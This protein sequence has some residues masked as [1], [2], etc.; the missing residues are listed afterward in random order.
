MHWEQRNP[1]LDLFDIKKYM[2]IEVLSGATSDLWAMA[3][4]SP[5]A[6]VVALLQELSAD[7]SV[8][9][10]ITERAD[11]WL[12]RLRISVAPW[13]AARERRNN[14]SRI[15]ILDSPATNFRMIVGFDWR[16]RRAAVLAVLPK[17]EHTYEI[18]SDRG[19]ARSG[20]RAASADGRG[21]RGGTA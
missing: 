13:R 2:K 18:F 17:D 3:A 15:R 4:G 1:R 21:A 14:L 16:Q 10:A 6:A 20:I 5:P 11:I 8:L 19:R 12:G 9:E 7:F